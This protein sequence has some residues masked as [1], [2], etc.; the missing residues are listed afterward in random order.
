ME[1]DKISS[2]EHHLIL[3]PEERTE[4]LA[5]L[6]QA[7]RTKLVEIRRTDTSDYRKYVKHQEAIFQVLIDKLKQC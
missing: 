7:D 1:T 3:T 5:L 4:L 2:T 6:E